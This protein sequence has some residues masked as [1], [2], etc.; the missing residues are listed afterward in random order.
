MYLSL[1]LVALFCFN[2]HF[3]PVSANFN[4]RRGLSDIYDTAGHSRY[5]SLKVRIAAPI[6]LNHAAYVQSRQGSVGSPEPPAQ[7]V[8]TLASAP[9]YSPTADAT[10]STLAAATSTLSAAVSSVAAAVS[11]LD[12]VT[13]SAPAALSTPD[14]PIG[15][16]FAA[17]S[18]A[19]AGT[20]PA[21]ASISRVNHAMTSMDP[22]NSTLAPCTQAL[23]DLNDQAM[24]PSGMAICYNVL[25]FDNTTGNFESVLGL[26]Q[27][28]EAMGDWA[29]V[30]QNNMNIGVIYPGATIEMEDGS[31]T[32]RD[33]MLVWPA[34]LHERDAPIVVK[35]MDFVGQV[36]VMIDQLTNE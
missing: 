24:S 20:I 35:D 12:A 34:E 32:K 14:T 17:A 5:V 29:S 19:D 36:N 16:A 33:E 10:V 23:T 22:E 9:T 25:Q 31:N 11:M 8:P 7:S 13:S 30:Q 6:P 1:V 28:G 21:V 15:A 4:L 27:V 26:Y 3:L 18:T 2:Q